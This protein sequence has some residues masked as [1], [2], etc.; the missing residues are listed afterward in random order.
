[1]KGLFH[2]REQAPSSGEVERVSPMARPISSYDAREVGVLVQQWVK[3]RGYRLPHRTL[4]EAA[5]NIGTTSVKLHRY[6]LNSLGMDFR[7]W[8]TSLRI[9]DAKKI[10]TEEPSLPVSQVGRIVGI[11]DRSNFFRQFS[12]ATG[13]TPDKWRQEH[14]KR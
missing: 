11:N 7:A 9:E 12:L 14:S 8:R 6:C 4:Q 3:N 13:V 2:K 5:E 10:M 1:M